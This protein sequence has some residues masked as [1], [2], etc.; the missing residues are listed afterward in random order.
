[1]HNAKAHTFMVQDKPR[2]LAFE[3]AIRKIVRPGDHVLD[4]GTG[5]GVLAMLAVRAGAAHVDAVERTDVAHLA[6]ELVTRNGMQDRITIHRRDARK[7][8]LE[9]PAD[10]LITELIGDQIYDEDIVRL[11]LH[12]RDHLLTPDARICPETLDLVAAPV[13]WPAEHKRLLATGDVLGLDFAPARR[14]AFNLPALLKKRPSTRF[15][16]PKT[17]IA[18]DFTSVRED[19]FPLE[20]EAF[21]TAN[22]SG[23]CHGFYVYFH[24]RLAPRVTLSGDEDTHWHR[25]FLPIEPAARVRKGDQI[26]LQLVI[27][28]QSR[29]MW[30]GVVLRG[31]ELIHSSTHSHVFADARSMAKLMRMQ[32]HFR[33]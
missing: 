17:V 25:L 18:V 11:V 3:R 28:E 27:D 13:S 9:Q 4:L 10:V 33:K 16:S 15:G 14:T 5:T 6:R 23:T 22:R 19:P 31:D 21:W 24:S 7:L 12:A 20:E 29:Y 1:M 2:M 26:G 30:T 32:R 8:T